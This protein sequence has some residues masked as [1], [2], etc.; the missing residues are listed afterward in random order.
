M[1]PHSNC[2]KGDNLPVIPYIAIC[3]ALIQYL[4]IDKDFDCYCMA[5][6]KQGFLMSLFC[7][8]PHPTGSKELNVSDKIQLHLFLNAR[9]KKK[10]EA[11]KVISVL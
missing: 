6:G 9:V 5:D 11:K 10:T 3:A 7:S 8:L 4:V 2:L 1:A